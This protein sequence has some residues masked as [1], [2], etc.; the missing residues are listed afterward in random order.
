MK[1][2]G[3]PVIPHIISGKLYSGVS[4]GQC[5]AALMLHYVPHVCVW[6]GERNT[7]LIP[8]WRTSYVIEII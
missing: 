5:L 8:S 4:D 3:V 2:G 6:N 1:Y 7:I